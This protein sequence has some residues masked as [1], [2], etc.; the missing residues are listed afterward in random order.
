MFRNPL[1]NDTGYLAVCKGNPE[2]ILSFQVP[3]YPSS[4]DYITSMLESSTK[5]NFFSD[6]Y[7]FMDLYVKNV[8][9]K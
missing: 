9:I 1:I 7:K 4:S 8:I 3:D 6:N 2:D 5:F